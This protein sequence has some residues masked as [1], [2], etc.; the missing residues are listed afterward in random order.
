MCIVYKTLLKIY[1]HYILAS[2]LLFNSGAG[3][4]QFTFCVQSMISSPFIDFVH[5]NSETVTRPKYIGHI[6]DKKNQIG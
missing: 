4:L 2:F 3:L 1:I 6:T 5:T